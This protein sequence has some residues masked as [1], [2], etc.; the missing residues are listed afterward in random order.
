MKGVHNY[1]N[2][3]SEFLSMVRVACCRSAGLLRRPTEVGFF[4]DDLVKLFFVHPF[5]KNIDLSLYVSSVLLYTFRA[6]FFSVN[7]G[8][9]TKIVAN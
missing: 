8:K 1:Q 4:Y 6:H 3:Q 9:T 7:Y 2:F 5:L